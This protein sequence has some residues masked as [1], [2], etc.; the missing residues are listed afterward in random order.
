M[1]PAIALFPVLAVALLLAGA[2]AQASSKTDNRIESSARKSYVFK[3]YLKGDDIKIQSKDG[4]VTLTG[5]VQK[6]PTNRW[7]GRPSRN[8]PESRRWTTSWK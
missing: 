5:S 8:F 1:K 3:T 7:R 4:V 6:S 2:P